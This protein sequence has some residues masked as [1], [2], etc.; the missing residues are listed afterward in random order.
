MARRWMRLDLGWDDADWVAALDKGGQLAWVK[1][2]CYAKATGTGGRVRALS[3]VVAARKWG[4]APEDVTA[5]LE[6]GQHDDPPAIA[7]EGREWVVV[8]FL[9][10]N[11][12]DGTAAERMRRMR[13][14]QKT[15]V[16]ENDTPLRRNSRNGRRNPSRATETGT[17]TDTTETDSGAGA[18]GSKK[19]KWDSRRACDIWTKHMGGTA[20]G[21]R[22]GKALKPLVEKYG[23]VEVLKAWDDYLASHVKNNTGQYANVNDFATRYGYFKKHGVKM[24]APNG[25]GG[26]K[27]TT[28][29]QQYGE[30]TQPG[31]VRWVD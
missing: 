23:E 1:L 14:R 11:P 25:N 26:R 31:A 17:E 28:D 7:I 8:N 29:Q 6:A 10:Y 18:P 4:V 21:G 20:P 19:P 27:R 13:E 22:I 9:E 30:G 15:V 24:A 3:P 2:L 12:H 16:T 5:M